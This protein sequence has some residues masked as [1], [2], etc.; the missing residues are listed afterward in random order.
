MIFISVAEV[1]PNGKVLPI[2]I[3]PMLIQVIAPIISLNEEENRQSEM[4]MQDGSTIYTEENCFEI[5]EKVAI[6]GL[7]FGEEGTR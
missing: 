5:L 4:T 6:A 7:G 1:R 2:Y 3:N